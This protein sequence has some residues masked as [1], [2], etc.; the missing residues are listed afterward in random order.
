MA[1][2]VGREREIGRLR[3]LVDGLASGTTTRDQGFVLV[4]GEAGIGK[5]H[6]LREV[7]VY[8]EDQGVTVLRATGWEHAGTPAFWL[9]SQVLRDLP[10]ADESLLSGP[11]SGT[12]AATEA[13]RFPLFAMVTDVLRRS[14][15][16][17]PAMLVLDDLHD[18]DAESLRML[19]FVVD[20]E[21]PRV[22]VLGGWRDHETDDPER[23]ATLERLCA[24]GEVV[25]LA[26]LDRDDV[27]ALAATA[28]ADLDTTDVDA[29]VQR[30][31]GNPLFVLE[32]TR[33]QAARGGD[34]EA[35][36]VPDSVQGTVR[37][38]LARLD[39]PTY[40]VLVAAAVAGPEVDPHWLA[41]AL[42]S[43]LET[44]VSACDAATERGLLVEHGPRWRFAHNLIREGVAQALPTTGRRQ[45]HATLAAALPPPPYDDAT[46]ARLAHHRRQALGVVDTRD[47]VEAG[48]AWADRLAESQAW[49]QAV[50]AYDDLLALLGPEHGD[51][52]ERLL[53]GLGESALVLAHPRA[54]EA[55]AEL[56][57]RAKTRGDAE[58]MAR[59]ALGFAAGLGGFEVRLFD[60]AQAELLT[61]A[62][63]AMEAGDDEHVALRSRLMSR[64][65]VAQSFVEPT[66]SRRTLSQAAVDLARRSGDDDALA[67]ALAAHNDSVAGPEHVELRRDMATEVIDLSRSTRQAPTR[68]LGLRHRIV[69]HWE[70]GDATAARAD[71]REFERVATELGQPLYSWY[72]PLWQ[73]FEALF[74]GDA[75]RVIASADEAARVGG[76]VD[77]KNAQTLGLVQ[78]FWGL[79]V[80]QQYGGM[81]TLM[82]NA[83]DLDP[84]LAPDG[85]LLVGLFPGRTREVREA[86]VARLPELVAALP[87]DAEWLS[88]LCWVAHTVVTERLVDGADLLYRTLLPYRDLITVDGIAAGTHGSVARML[89][90]LAA[91]LG[92]TETARE[93]L[94][95]ALDRN[96][97]LGAPW[98]V[99]QTH[100]WIETALGAASVD[101]PGPTED[102]ASF[103]REGD[104]WT[105]QFRGTSAVLRPSK[106]LEDL[107]TLLA[108]P[109]R[110]LPALH[111]A[112]GGLGDGPHEGGTGPLLDDQA[113]EA[114]R[115][116]LDVL[117]EDEADAELAGDDDRAA[118]AREEREALVEQLSAAYGLGG[119]ARPQGDAAERART[120]VTWR[121][122]DA[123]KR[124]DAVHPELARHLRNAIRTGHYC[125]YQPE[126]S[127]SWRL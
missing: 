91:L 101:D 90:G 114:F 41:A 13:D 115:R 29:L 18:A 102:E 82:A 56:F 16:A 98:L 61:E 69:A 57:A 35:S 71:M 75:A 83:L 34:R 119:R 27:A 125:S 1:A 54:R 11:G 58:L 47:V 6:L 97:A 31:G 37:R 28:G 17:A 7:A 20:A 42:G 36:A 49:E 100:E 79:F 70:L 118:R 76:Q 73:G 117:A 15:D 5:S 45:L 25:R 55:F 120:T 66:A 46:L 65:A 88:N 52:R 74:Q 44:V 4:R 50:A 59:A 103:R 48:A 122:R 99:A 110:E 10:G 104:V 108:S 107:A 94:D 93:H 64:L 85:A 24:Q 53:L 3:A 96:R 68:L 81:W 127:V 8:G 23:V 30:T 116:R 112:R 19:E 113:K 126:T 32:T 106:G 67:G 2:T 62:I 87:M 72:V 124:I 14:A 9:W 33:L 84:H 77:S 92:D 80:A 95:L 105:M 89:G 39:Q 26:A 60:S 40:E 121:I 123:I 86:T 51:L 78:H 12:D 43:P 63:E 111:L 38:R 22:L 21:L 109:G